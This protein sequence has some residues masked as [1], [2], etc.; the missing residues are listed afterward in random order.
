[1]GLT[2]KTSAEEEAKVPRRV[3]TGYHSPPWHSTHQCVVTNPE[4]Q[5]ML[6]ELPE[7]GTAFK[8]GAVSLRVSRPELDTE[9]QLQLDR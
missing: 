4:I 5:E 7:T 8:T 3:T 9:P 2:G 1:M 6:R